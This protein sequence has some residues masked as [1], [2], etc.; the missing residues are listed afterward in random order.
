VREILKEIDLRMVY[1]APEGA[2]YARKEQG[3][4]K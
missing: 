1:S 3:E 2:I 4:N